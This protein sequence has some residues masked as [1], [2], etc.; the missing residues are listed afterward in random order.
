MMW[1]AF[2]LIALTDGN[3]QQIWQEANQA[4]QD[5]SFE[6]AA[7]LYE[8]LLEQGVRSGDLHYNLGNA[9][10]RQGRLGKAILHYNRAQKYLPGDADIAANLEL[11]NSQRQDPPIDEENEDLAKSFNHLAHMLPYSVIFW[12][13][14]IGLV[15]GGLASLGMVIKPGV[16]KAL[17][18]LMVIGWVLGLIFSSGAWLQ[19]KELTRKDMAIITVE[20]VDV[21]SGPSMRETVSFTIHE[22]IGCRIMDEN[23]G[24]YRIR[25]ANGYNGWV[26]SGDLEII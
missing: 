16:H 23:D 21:L 13:A 25:L 7:E 9:Y 11:A 17:G 19:Y 14:L 18:Y 15:T 6:N 8:H 22:G 5:E 3:T 20:R 24:W 2:C 26:R 10:Y 4:Y 12:I 1:L